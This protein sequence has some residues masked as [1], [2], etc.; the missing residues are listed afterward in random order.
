MWAILS[1]KTVLAILCMQFLQGAITIVQLFYTWFHVRFSACNAL[2]FLCHNCRLS[3]VMENIH[4][5]KM[6][7]PSIFF[8]RLKNLQLLH[9]NCSALH[10]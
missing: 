9:K 10:A 5:A 4:E 8:I 3:N 1:V 7:Q 6:L 2:K